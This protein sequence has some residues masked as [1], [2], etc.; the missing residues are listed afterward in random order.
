MSKRSLKPTLPAIVAAGL[1]LS[2]G[3]QP[4]VAQSQYCA[5]RDRIVTELTK[6]HGESRQSVG[7]QRNSQV[8]ETW[9]NPSTGSWTIIVSLPTGL[10]CLVAA[11]EAFQEDAE[12]AK[13]D[14]AV[15]DEPA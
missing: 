6:K 4:A 5:P 14:P 12:G 8:M 9:A 3:V 13:V 1:I 10:S 11:G 7:L 2:C 15:A